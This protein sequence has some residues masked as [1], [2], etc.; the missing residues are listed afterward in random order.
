[1]AV[2]YTFSSNSECKGSS[3]LSFK[4]FTEEAVKPFGSDI[5]VQVDRNP[6]FDTPKRLCVEFSRRARN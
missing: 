3:K 4:A 5:D 2:G 6:S 1:M